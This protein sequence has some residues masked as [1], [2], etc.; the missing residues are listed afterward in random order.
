M[1]ILLKTTDLYIS[2]IYKHFDFGYAEGGEAGYKL[3][4]LAEYM[5][6][7]YVL[8]I[9]GLLK[10][11]AVIKK[12]EATEHMVEALRTMCSYAGN[13]G[14]IVTLEEYDNVCAPYT[15]ADEILWF[16]KKVPGLKHTFDT[17][18]YRYRGEDE[19]AALELLKDYVVYVHVKDRSTSMQGEE[20]AKIAA[21]GT[22]LFS[23]P[24]GEGIIKI[25]EV[26]KIL[27]NIGYDG[28]LNIEHF[29]AMNQMK[30]IE[31]STTWLLDH[32]SKSSEKNK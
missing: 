20:V 14:I 13:K 25:K 3:I 21:D 24:V 2:C 1:K 9:P 6:A 4:D 32:I 17:G 16:M 27:Q 10:E 28:V 31:Q 12:E 30:Y 22:P 18:N 19:V 26:I 23:T 15:T 11:N 5:G 29:N 7:K 8:V